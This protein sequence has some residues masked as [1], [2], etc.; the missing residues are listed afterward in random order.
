MS[1]T[2][3]PLEPAPAAASAWQRTVAAVR[4]RFAGLSRARAQLQS[5]E[6][7]SVSE[8]LDAVEQAATALQ[9]GVHALT[10][11]VRRLEEAVSTHAGHLAR[12]DAR[13]TSVEAR[14][15][16]VEARL[17]AQALTRAASSHGGSHG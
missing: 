6:D 17:A 14:T 16:Q 9:A 11:S 8:A 4:Q 3:P 5:V 13:L 15:T 1:G 10:R 12:Q 2:L 7:S